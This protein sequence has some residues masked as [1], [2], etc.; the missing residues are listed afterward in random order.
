MS[1]PNPCLIGIALV[2]KKKSEPHLVFH[3]PPRP[4]EDNSYFISL[5]KTD[6]FDTTSSSSDDDEESTPEDE[7]PREETNDA[8]KQD[9]PPDIAGSG[10]ASPQKGS[11]LQRGSKRLLW[12][13]V[14]GY[15]S[16]VLAKALCP[17]RHSHRRFEMSLGNN[18]VLGRPVYVKEDGRW[19][20]RKRRQRSPSVT[21]SVGAKANLARDKVKANL[22]YPF[23]E[24]AEDSSHMSSNANS[25]AAVTD[26]KGDSD[27]AEPSSRERPFLEEGSN[28][29]TINPTHPR[30][31]QE[32]VKDNM[33]MFHVVFVL[34][35]PP[36][37]Y[38]ARVKDLY[39]HVVKK[40]TRAL[41]WEQARSGYVAKE[42]SLIGSVAAKLLSANRDNPPLATLY[43]DLINQSSLAKAMATLYNGIS[44]SKI[45]HLSLTS[46]TSLSLQIPRATSISILPTPLAPQTPGLWLT[47]TTPLPTEDEVQI[48]GSRLSPQF[49]LLLLSDL[50]SILADVRAAASPISDLLSHY[51]R[52]SKSTKSFLQISQASG[53]SLPDIQLLA[54]HLIYWRR[55]RAIPPLRQ[56]DVYIVSPNADVR[57]LPEASF[58]FAKAFPMMPPLPRFLSMLSATPKPYSTLIPN[59]DRKDVFMEI[60]A[61][62][63]RG[64][65]VTQLQTFV[66]VR[67]P[68]QIKATVDAELNRECKQEN[69]ERAMDGVKSHDFAPN[70]SDKLDGSELN[71]TSPTSS[72]NTALRYI[73]LPSPASA[74]IISDPQ[75]ASGLASR[76][77]FAVSIHIRESQSAD[78]KT[79]W[80]ICLRY[81]DGK[82]AVE[83]IAVRE[84]WKRKRVMELVAGWEGLGTLSKVR[85]W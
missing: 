49:T 40:F 29:D 2:I 65:W 11:T 78:T 21:N 18:V 39:D 76:Y 66:W 79:A 28:L 85:H 16:S 52:V 15:N 67:I 77:L 46:T 74:V 81:F 61:W 6:S 31:G 12:N 9:S 1:A 80:D 24:A 3:Y 35:P 54:S 17:T 5:F 83:S 37:E 22:T 43:H 55:A 63:L 70:R 48:D 19:I 38:H 26:E 50:P 10:S 23:Q 75:L 73:D 27:T 32:G 36:L 84:G 13:D 62:M 45:A 68:P 34:R 33:V 4:G 53:I 8:G 14:F 58:R 82:H 72:T 56:S 42:S 41:K 59:K 69:F 20:R 60:L 64:G 7:P 71:G 51:L 30:A 25:E 57:D 47:T 44:N